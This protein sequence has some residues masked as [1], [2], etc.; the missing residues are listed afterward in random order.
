VHWKALRE[1]LAQWLK[2]GMFVSTIARRQGSIVQMAMDEGW[3]V[4]GVEAVLVPPM[5]RSW[6]TRRA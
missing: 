5:R 4:N 3:T 1:F 2:D 6:A